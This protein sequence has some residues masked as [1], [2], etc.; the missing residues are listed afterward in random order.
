VILLTGGNYFFRIIAIIFSDIVVILGERS[1]RPGFLAFWLVISA[2]NI[3]AIFLLWIGIGLVVYFMEVEHNIIY[4]MGI[5]SLSD[6]WNKLV[7]FVK[8]C[9]EQFL[10]TAMLS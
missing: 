6:I 4:F 5:K 10:T 8:K 9:F 7:F 2:L 3:T 1:R